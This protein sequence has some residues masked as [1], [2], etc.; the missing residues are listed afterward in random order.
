MIGNNKNLPGRGNCYMK[1]HLGK[2]SQYT[3]NI[4]Y[5]PKSL[6]TVR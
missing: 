6:D 2:I 5:L 4:E 1:I 3:E